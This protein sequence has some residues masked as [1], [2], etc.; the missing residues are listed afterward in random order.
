MKIKK[1]TN[2]LVAYR[3]ANR[4]VIGHAA[5]MAFTLAEVL[6]TLGVI[7]VVAA[8]TLPTLIQ[9]YE[10]HV[11]TNRL[12]VNF[13]IMSNVVRMAEAH[14]GE[15]A[16]W[17]L[18]SNAKQEYETTSNRALRVQIAKKYIMPYLTG[19]QLTET[20][21]LKQLGYKTPIVFPDGSVWFNLDNSG[22]II[23]LNNGTVILL[24][25]DTSPQDPVTGKMIV[26]GMVLYM[27]INGP[28]GK[29][30]VGKDIFVSEIP[31]ANKAK[32]IMCENWTLTGGANLMRFENKNRTDILEDCK[33]YAQR[34]GR[35]IEFDGWEIKDDYP[36]L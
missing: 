32:F 15:I 3:T 16:E 17:D 27:D 30:T 31:F 34:C 23:R 21:T 35:L 20:T 22:P 8:L 36:Y 13:N 12:K 33:L 2:I 28:Q 29:N 14:S 7:G 18:V 5:K 9:N 6:I 1:D 19:A 11:I 24:A 4:R 25:A 10:K 26:R